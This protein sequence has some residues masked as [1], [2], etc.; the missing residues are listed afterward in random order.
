MSKTRV[1]G[2]PTKYQ[3]DKYPEMAM[4][5]CLLGATSDQLSDL[6][7][8]SP[9]TI[10][11][12]MVKY[13]KFLCAI[14]EGRENADAHVANS[15]YHRALGYSHPEEKIFCNNGELVRTETTKHYPPDTAAAFIWLKNRHP[16]LWRDRKEITGPDGGA[17]QVEVG[18]TELARRLAY[19]L[20]LGVEKDITP[21]NKE[22]E[23]DS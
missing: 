13:P 7:E 15:L 12:W 14:R 1:I 21:D 2:R 5:H 9:S 17:I 6:F 11:G 16:D 19:V 18:A 3:P 4:R 10:D 20:A 8:V 22:L 23:H